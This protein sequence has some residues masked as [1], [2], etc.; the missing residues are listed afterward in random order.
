M[1]LKA[2]EKVSSSSLMLK[3]LTLKAFDNTSP[4]LRSGNPGFK[5]QNDRL[6]AESVGDSSAVIPRVARAQP[7][8]L[9]CERFQRLRRV[10]FARCSFHE[11]L[12]HTEA[13]PETAITRKLRPH[14][15]LHAEPGI[16]QSF[17]LDLQAMVH[18][19]EPEARSSLFCDWLIPS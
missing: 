7:W 16:Q 3:S 8:A 4:G 9:A 19:T 15:H 1:P 18:R 12:I 13:K 10:T 17:E 11:P 6:N 14:V 2:L 5:R